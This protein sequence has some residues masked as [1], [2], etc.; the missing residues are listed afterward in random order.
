VYTDTSTNAVLSLFKNT[1]CIGATG[2]R[3]P[4]TGSSSG[5]FIQLTKVIDITSISPFAL[6]MRLGTKYSGPILTVGDRF[7]ELGLPYLIITETGYS[8]ITDNLYTEDLSGFIITETYEH[9]I[10]E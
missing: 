8:E 10:K 2:I 3:L 1:G 5:H 7:N 6:S 9:L 4:N